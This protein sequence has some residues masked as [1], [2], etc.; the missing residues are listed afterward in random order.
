MP[1]ITFET[2]ATEP[3]LPDLSC[4]LWSAFVFHSAASK[5]LQL[6]LC[7]AVESNAV[8]LQPTM[9]YLTVHWQSKE[10]WKL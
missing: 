4:L 3:S 5:H 7:L 8:I 9:P 10:S 1:Y 6:E 2:V